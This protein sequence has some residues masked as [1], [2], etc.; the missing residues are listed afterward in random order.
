MIHLICF[1]ANSSIFPTCHG[2]GSPKCCG[3]WEQEWFPQMLRHTASPPAPRLC[4]GDT[5]HQLLAA[6]RDSPQL[7]APASWFAWF[8][9]NRSEKAFQL[10]YSQIIW[11]LCCL[12]F[13]TPCSDSYQGLLS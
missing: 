10:G 8:P 3:W 6:D 4:S 5:L 11:E 1:E 2:Y 12:G 9:G 7:S 13:V